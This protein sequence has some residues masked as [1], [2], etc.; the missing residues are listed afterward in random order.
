MSSMLNKLV[1][2]RQLLNYK[3]TTSVVFI[4]KRQLGCLYLQLNL[5][6][7]VAYLLQVVFFT[8][9]LQFLQ[10][11][12]MFNQ[13]YS[14]QYLSNMTNAINMYR[15]TFDRNVCL[16]LIVYFTIT[17]I[18]SEQ[19]YDDDEEAIADKHHHHHPVPLLQSRDPAIKQFHILS[20][21]S[22]GREHARTLINC[23][24]TFKDSQ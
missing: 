14:L 19:K 7:Q 23:S 5:S 8:T 22:Q 13:I 9:W 3:K 17:A 15:F 12:C 20:T 1:L 2:K 21:L 18:F 4:D 11:G 24:I 6:F 16:I 10:P